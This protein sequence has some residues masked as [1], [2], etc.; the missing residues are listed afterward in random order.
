ME[1][2]KSFDGVMNNIHEGWPTFDDFKQESVFIDKEN[3][4]IV[5]GLLKKYRR[6]LIRGAKGRGKTVLSRVVGFNYYKDKWKIRFIDVQEV[7]KENID[8]IC[9]YIDRIEDENFL[10][11]IENAHASL[12]EI[13]PKLIEIANE[14]HRDN[15]IFVSRKIFPGEEQ[16]LIG[17]PFEE[18][19]EKELHL[20]LTPGLEVAHGIINIAAKKTNY[21]L[22]EQDECWIENEFGKETINLRRLKWYLD[23]W[24]EIGGPLSLVPKERVFE[25]VLNDFFIEKLDINLRRMLLNV[26]G[27]FQ[28]DVYFYGRDYDA[29]I[30]TGLVKRGVITFIGGDYYRLQHSSDAAYIIEAEAKLTARKEP[31]VVTTEILTEY[32][33]SKPENYYE[34]MKALFQSKEEPI[35]S[36]IFN[37]QK[38]YDA[39]FDMVKQ[40]HISVV[41]WFLHYLTWACSKEKGLEF[42]SQ[43]KKLGGDSPEEQKE[44][45]KSKLNEATLTEVMILLQSL[46]KVDSNERIWLANEVLDEAD[47]AQKAEDRSFST[48][49]NLMR[50]LPNEKTSA[51]LSK[52]DP[53]DIADKAKSS[54]AQ[55]IMWFLRGCLRDTSNINF[56]NSFL[57]AIDKDE[58][59]LAQKAEDASFSVINGLVNV[60]PTEKISAVISKLNPN[61]M[62]E[63]AKSTNTQHITWFL[64]YCLRDT[65]NINFLNSFL[66]ALNKKGDLAEKFKNSDIGIVRKCLEIIKKINPGLS[67]ELNS[68]ISPYWLQICL[69]SNLTSIAWEICEDSVPIKTRRS[70]V[71]KLASKELSEPIRKLYRN[72]ESEPLKTL[73][74]LLH[75]VHQV[76]FVTDR[77]AVE[78]IAQQI[79]NN[80]NFKAQ[81]KYDPTQLSLLVNNAKKCNELAWGQLCSR[82]ISELNMSDYI[83]IPFENGS[84]VLVWQIYQYDGEKGKELANEIF[85][86]DFNKLLD[87]SEAEAVKTLLWNLFQIN[88]SEVRSWIQNM[89]DYIR[90]PLE[91]GSAELIWVIYQYDE[92]TGKELANEIFKLD[93]NKLLDSSEAEA[94]K[95]LLWNLLQINESEVRSWIQNMDEDKFLSKVLSSSTDEAFRLLWNLYQIDEEKGKMVAHSLANNVLS[96]LTAIETKDIPLLG[97]FVFCNI[98]M[99]LNMSIPSPGEIAEEIIEDLE[100]AELAFCL[101]F[102]E[103]GDDTLRKEFLKELGRRFFLRNLTF[104]PREMIEKHPIEN[105]RHFYL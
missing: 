9:R 90:I 54:T 75:C 8:G 48:I 49:N 94:V 105:I 83:R 62:A 3:A 43:Y 61:V 29:A 33:Q 63:K 25:K 16:L 1:Q 41:S 45:L 19:E 78:K 51:F 64:R 100:L 86:L 87:S 40:D 27:V 104:P 39:I 81:E 95:Q 71:N 102:L 55:T 12:E 96:D 89:S 58:D 11:I 99:D 23:A 37:D 77:D 47:L 74:K 65:S 59:V 4:K 101:C 28:F 68:S 15:F 21:K 10:F 14:H 53:T 85:K 82:I 17:N 18:W 46:N 88:E 6:C 84:A 24:S 66:F 72:P 97:F 13:T 42:W 57:F 50:F 56:L 30:L 52:L 98:K 91:K 2:P 26:S 32:L 44:K 92:E 35:L 31:V 93:F 34:L 103:R 70:I 73:S 80:I 5:D 76:A 7:R 36:E 20:D 22:T 60:L 38:T 79:V 69:S 67:E